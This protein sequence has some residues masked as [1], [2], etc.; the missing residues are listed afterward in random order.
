[1]KRKVRFTFVSDR[2]SRTATA[3]LIASVEAA[4]GDG[5]A[6]AIRAVP[7]ER[8]DEVDFDPGPAEFVVMSAMT[9]NFP[10]R[11]QAL[12]SLK[13]K[14]PGAF[15]SVIGGPHAT[16]DPAGAVAAGFDYCCVGE[17]EETIR[18]IYD[19]AASG[20]P[21]EDVSGLFSMRGGK[22]AGEHRY[23]SVD[24]DGFD[25]LPRRVRFPACIEV[26]RGCRWGCAYCQTPRIFGRAERFRSP[27]RVADIASHYVAWGMKDVRLL[28]PNAL[29]YGSTRPGAPDCQ[30]LEELLGRVQSSCAGS[31][32][33]LGSF[34]SEVRPDYVTP[35]AVAILRKHVSND[36]LVIGG[37]SGSDRILMWLERGHS[38]GDILRA[39]EVVK[40]GGFAASVDLMLGFPVEE[41]DDREATFDLVE[42]LGR[43]G[44]RVNMHFLMPL[45]GTPLSD[46]HPRF[47]S[48]DERRR[49]DRLAQQGIVR[50]HWR[51]QEEASRAWQDREEQNQNA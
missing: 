17:G 13:Q 2:A 8:L 29:S 23:S 16:A 15:T 24:L 27:G 33:Y 28:L 42:R 9:Q 40:A 20:L 44:T 14:Q 39:S 12:A 11:A 48:G 22:V 31:R 1:M 47:L 26:G 37:Q 30:A 18:D 51:R 21:L 19:C 3:A 38:A 41:P 25:P 50:G 36:N 5:Y 10:M 49:L 7:H 35:E 32:I 46:C 43:D 45:P 4:A 6:G 34:P